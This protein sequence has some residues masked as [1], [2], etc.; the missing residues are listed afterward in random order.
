MTDFDMPGL[1][2]DSV[3]K[4]LREEH[5]TAPIILVSAIKHEVG[6]KKDF[7]AFLQKPV[8]ESVFI[9][10]LVKFLKHDTIPIE[11]A[12]HEEESYEFVIPENLVKEELELVKEILE[13]FSTWRQ[14][15]PVSEIEIGCQTLREKLTKTKLINLIPLLEKLEESAENFNINMLT[16]LLDSAIEKIKSNKISS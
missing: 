12:T 7:D 16:T 5:T 3:L 8:D 11:E 9:Q 6:I 14:Y 15:M 1:N 4:T 10:G 13:K 2:V